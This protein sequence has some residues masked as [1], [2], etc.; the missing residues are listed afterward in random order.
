MEWKRILRAV[1]TG[2]VC[3]GLLLCGASAAE[4]NTPEVLGIYSTGGFHGGIYP[5]DPLTGE[6]VETS[7][8]KVASVM[9]EQRRQAAETILLDSGDALDG[10]AVSGWD[11][12][13]DGDPTALALRMIGYDALIPG[14]GEL[15]APSNYREQTFA[16]LT[17]EEGAGEPVA[18]LSGNLLDTKGQEPL[19][20]PCRIFTVELAG[21]SWQVGVAGLGAL[22]GGTQLPAALQKELRFTHRGNQ[23]G[24][25]AWEWNQVLAP[26]LA[27]AGACDFIV[28]VVGTADVAAFVAQTR[29]IDLVLTHTGEPAAWTCPNADGVEVP[30]LSSGGSALTRTLVGVSSEGT[31]TVEEYGLLELA[32]SPNEPELT[33]TLSEASRQASRYADRTVSSLSGMWDGNEGAPYSQTDAFDLTARA[34]C[35]AAEADAALLA[36]AELG[37]LSLD[38][39]AQDPKGARSAGL[40]LRDCYTLCPPSGGALCLVEMSGAQIRQWLDTCAGRYGVDERGSLTGGEDAD[41]LYGLDYELY[42]GGVPGNRVEGLAWEGVPVK[43]SHLFRVAVA[44]GR[45]ADPEF[46]QVKVLWTASTD[47]R[48]AARGGSVPAVLAEYGESLSLLTPLRESTWSVYTGRSDGPINR[49]EFIAMLYELAGKPEPA[50]DTA[51]VDLSGNTAAVWAAES[52]IVSGDGQGRFLPTQSVTREQAAVILTRF[53][54]ARGLDTALYEGAVGELADCGQVSAWA[55]PAVEFCCGSGIMPAGGQTFLPQDTFTRQE[56]RTFL[57]VLD[58]LLE[59]DEAD[60]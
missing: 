42:V 22:D 11:L 26:A 45:L 50:V 3:A 30:C 29:G 51:F 6:G 23:D 44:S 7:Y 19:L 35:W 4:K 27:E 46:P 2:A 33:E 37:E 36:P 49:L 38:S 34:M 17:A 58:G 40:S 41:A 57:T 15:R 47:P 59:R 55:L 16:Q 56:A 43:D 21:R 13:L 28:A 14:L 54:Q 31:L 1:L 5:L 18:L 48:F 39:L 12:R 8:L 32:G 52:G 25:Y 60:L 10:G 24:S 20:E 9:E 53:A